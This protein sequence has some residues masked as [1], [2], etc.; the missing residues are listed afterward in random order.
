MRKMKFPLLYLFLCLLFPLTAFS[1]NYTLSICAIFQNEAR[2]LKEWIEYHRLVGVEHFWLYNNNSSDHFLEVLDPYVKQGIVDLIDWRSN[3]PENKYEE[4]HFKTKM[5]VYNECLGRSKNVSK[6]VA[7]IDSNEFLVPVHDGNLAQMLE[8]QFSV[9]SGLCIY[10]QTFGTSFVYELSPQD[11]MIE[12]MSLKAGEN[13]WRNRCYKM[14]VQPLHVDHFQYPNSC[15][16]VDS[17]W[18]INTNGVPEASGPSPTFDTIVIHH[19]WFRDEKFMNES[20]RWKFPI[21]IFEINKDLNSVE[22]TSM[23]RFVPELR[24]TMGFLSEIPELSSQ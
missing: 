22:D 7:F 19:Y 6:W 16:Y 10:E 1:Y 13:Y 14:I 21:D 12:R 20:Q 17:H 4:F 24:K 23:Q 2:F 8:T 15:V 11:L 5:N 3:I 18:A 9:V